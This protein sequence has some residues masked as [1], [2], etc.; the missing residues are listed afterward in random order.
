M[1]IIRCVSCEGYGWFQDEFSTETV[2][3]DWCGG[4]GY[5]YREAN[6]IDQRI[7]PEEY[8]KVADT[9]EK[10]E[11]QRMREMGYQGEAKKPWEQ[12]VR[13]DTQLGNRQP[14]EDLDL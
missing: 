3:C 2:D 12:A 10:L 7:P 6:G 14:P 9:L 4:V 13:K 1:T 5:V 11:L 8:A